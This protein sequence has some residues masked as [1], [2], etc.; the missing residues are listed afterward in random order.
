MIFVITKRLA[1]NRCG[2]ISAHRLSAE[3][4][5]SDRRLRRMIFAFDLLAAREGIYPATHSARILG[6]ID[7]R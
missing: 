1:L 3:N 7:G 2:A 6:V 4:A 5:N